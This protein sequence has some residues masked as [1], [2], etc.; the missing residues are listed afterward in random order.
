ML[1]FK[2]GQGHVAGERDR[3]AVVGHRE[4]ASDVVNCQGLVLVDGHN[5]QHV[6]EMSLEGGVQ[7]GLMEQ[8]IAHAGGLQRAQCRP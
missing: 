2:P 5:R 6:L 8:D 3:K 7:I 1:N 4:G